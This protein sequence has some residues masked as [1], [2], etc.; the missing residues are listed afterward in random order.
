MLLGALF[1]SATAGFY[2]LTQ[3]VMGA[4]MSLVAGALGD[5]FRQ[6]ASYAY[7]HHGQC[8]E[9]YQKTFKR[10]LLI[11]LVPFSVFFFV[12]PPIFSLVFGADWR[13]AG[14]YAQ[15][16]MPMFFLRFITSPLSSMFI[17]AERQRLDLIWQIFLLS[18]VVA[19]FMLGKFLL[20]ATDALK[21][22]SAAYSIGYSIN[23]VMTY[24]F[25]KNS[26][27]I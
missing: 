20:S 8:K 6:E 14:E 12:A 26:A 23:G 11:S 17:I 22:F 21:F 1:N 25:A 9:I 13:I 15:I 27:Q 24:N 4:P 16:L 18:L 2:T 7:A 5:V 10:L 19:S 3:R